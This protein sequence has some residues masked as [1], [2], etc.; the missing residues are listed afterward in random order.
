MTRAGYR[1]LMAAT[2]DEALRHA[3]QE[4]PGALLMGLPIRGQQAWSDIA[5]VRDHA[6]LK[7]VPIL[8]LGLPAGQDDHRAEPGRGLRLPQDAAS[9]SS[10]PAGESTSRVCRILL[11]EDDRDQAAVLI[12]MFQQH[13][14]ET[15]HARSGREAIAMARAVRPDLM[16]LDVGLPE[17]DGFY[18]IRG[19]RQDAGLRTVPLV[20]YSGRNLNAAE[21][22]QLRLGPT[23][24]LTKG[25]ISPEEF[26]R[27]VLNLLSHWMV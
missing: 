8:V 10:E 11:I 21:R 23:E 1:V 6:R 4:R 2:I 24:Y 17:G 20:V 3:E 18:V 13:H 22:H 27:H 16:V 26:E 15:V 7:D 5:Q 14:I 19:L 9:H 12:E 25:E